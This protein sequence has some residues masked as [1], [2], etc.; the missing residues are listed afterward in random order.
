ML[1]RNSDFDNAG[2][3]ESMS[4]TSRTAS[5]NCRGMYGVLAGGL[6]SATA[7]VVIALPTADADPQC[8]TTVGQ[9]A[10]QTVQS[11]LDAHPDIRAEL[12]AKAAAESG[13]SSSLLDYLNRHPDVRQA[14][15]TLANQCTS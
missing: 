1:A 8:N 4:A 9:S 12:T 14:L 10:S 11:Y 5:P 6:L 7:A 3:L 13:G 2:N 15:I